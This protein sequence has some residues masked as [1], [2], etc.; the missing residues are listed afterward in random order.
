MSSKDEKPKSE[1]RR[2][3][4]KLGGSG[5]AAGGAALVLR[6]GAAESA[7]AA[8]DQKAAGYRET[9]HVRKFYETARF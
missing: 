9:T 6:G 5:V 8:S 4:L 7:A 3:F 2:A 1:Q